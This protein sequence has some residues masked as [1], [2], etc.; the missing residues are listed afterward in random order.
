MG[1]LGKWELLGV[2]PITTMRAPLVVCDFGGRV[3]VRLCGGC[4]F[5]TLV[6]CAFASAI[7][8]VRSCGCA[9]GEVRLCGCAFG[10]APLVSAPMRL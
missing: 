7:L 1:A 8:R 10:D 4:D 3:Q 5:A 9:L 6:E 2:K